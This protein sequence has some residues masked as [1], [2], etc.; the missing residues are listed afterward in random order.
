MAES[1]TVAVMVVLP[2]LPVS[3]TVP[4]APS[5]IATFMSLDVYVTTPSPSFV[6]GLIKVESPIVFSISVVA[7]AILPAFFSGTAS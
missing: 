1:A 5:T 6:N 7:K 2:A 3:T 4:V